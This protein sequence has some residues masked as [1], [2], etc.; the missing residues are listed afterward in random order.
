MDLNSG[1]IHNTIESGTVP[2]PFV[3]W[4]VGSGTAAGFAATANPVL[5]KIAFVS[6]RAG[7]VH[8]EEAGS[9]HCDVDHCEGDGSFSNCCE[10]G[11]RGLKDERMSNI[12]G[13]IH[14]VNKMT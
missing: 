12:K 1:R 10:F 2:T 9:S 3:H 6:L 8:D 11:Q 13:Q 4:E 14:D 5:S 7:R